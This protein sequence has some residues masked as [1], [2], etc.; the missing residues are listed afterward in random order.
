VR[1]PRVDSHETW[2]QG[3]P[4]RKLLKYGHRF[5]V[6]DGRRKRAS[7]SVKLHFDDVPGV[8]RHIHA[9]EAVDEEQVN[10]LLHL[11]TREHRIDCTRIRLHS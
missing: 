4:S 5:V 6:V 7:D 3:H 1:L 2:I 9:L 11:L 10:P 8:W